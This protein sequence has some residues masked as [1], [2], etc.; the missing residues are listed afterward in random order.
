IRED[1]S[2]DTN[3]P[4]DAL[5]A[6]SSLLN[7]GVA[8]CENGDINGAVKVLDRMKRMKD[9]FE[10]RGGE[11]MEFGRDAQSYMREAAELE[12]SD[13]EIDIDALMAKIEE[14]FLSK[15][16]TAVQIA[17]DRVTQAF[18][19]KIAQLESELASR[20]ADVQAK[21]L[22]NVSIGFEGSELK[23]VIV[24]AKTD[25]MNAVTDFDNVL[26]AFE[27]ENIE[28]PAAVQDQ[29]QDIYEFATVRNLTEDAAQDLKAEIDAVTNTVVVAFQ[30]DPEAAVEVLADVLPALAEEATRIYEEDKD[31]QLEQGILAFGDLHGQEDD[32]YTGWATAAKNDGFLNGQVVNGERVM[33]ADA[34]TNWAEGLTMTA[35]M[36]AGGEGNIPNE[37]DLSNPVIREMPDWAQP[38]ATYL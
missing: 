19:L 35:R 17:V 23:D 7:E 32:W 30:K 37:V 13:G 6:A 16:E 10:G 26:V 11:D 25:V 33:N 8:Y 2:G 9:K 29:I 12:F 5:A 36:M 1:L 22:N 20:L 18:T 3:I 21:A 15:I 34:A 38:A 27:E 24:E 31:A 14:R 28:I 4:E